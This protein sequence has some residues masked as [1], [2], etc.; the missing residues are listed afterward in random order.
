MKIC[1]HAEWKQVAYPV[2]RFCIFKRRLSLKE[3]KMNA[4]KN[5]KKKSNENMT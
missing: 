5:V 3:K 1:T 2:K 4:E